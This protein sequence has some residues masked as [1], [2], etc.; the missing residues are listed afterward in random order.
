MDTNSS[1]YINLKKRR[2][3]Y[4]LWGILIVGDDFLALFKCSGIILKTQEL[5][6][7]DKLVVIYTDK[8][9][10]VNAVG[11]GAKRNRSKFLSSTL[12]FC[13]GD[14]VLFKGKNLYSINESMV[15][16]SFQELLQ[17]LESITYASYLCELVDICMVEEESNREFFRELITAFYLMK[18]KAVDFN[19]LARGIEVKLLQAAGYGLDFENINISNTGY[20]ILKYLSKVDIKNIYR[21]HVSEEN[22]NE[23]YKTLSNLI[24]INFGKKPKSL[25]TLNYI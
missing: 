11:K 20:N 19:L 22:C 18:N 1:V 6:D 15:I 16:D 12:Q 2:N 24:Y 23:L 25:E 8:I 5:N 13:V 9:G 10:K 7:N 14:Y 21:L 4:K 3:K 17:D